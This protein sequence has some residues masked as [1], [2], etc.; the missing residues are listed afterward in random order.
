MYETES[1]IVWYD[2]PYIIKFR[3]TGE[4]PF[5]CTYCPKKFILKT[6]RN[7]HERVHT[8]EKPYECE[9]CKARFS[10]SSNLRRHEKGYCTMK[11][12]IDNPRK[13]KTVTNVT[14]G[15][16]KMSEDVTIESSLKEPETAEIKVEFIE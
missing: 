8:G 3:H 16:T 10:S 15:A 4:K 9:L 13:I 14:E 1:G 2:W 7:S 5:Q 12:Y 11:N 6:D